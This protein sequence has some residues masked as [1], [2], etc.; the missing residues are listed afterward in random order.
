MREAAR[1]VPLAV[2]IIPDVFQVEDRLWSEVAPAGA[3]RARRMRSVAITR[4]WLEEHSFAYL[5]LLP[6][7]RGVRPLA[8]GELHLYKLNDTHFNARGNAVVGRALA[9]FLEKWP[10]GSVDGAAQDATP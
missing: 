5:D 4:K 3:D 9:A 8:D 7:L 6:V 10:G 2:M 1:G